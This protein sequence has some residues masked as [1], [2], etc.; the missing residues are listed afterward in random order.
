MVSQ[1][2]Y[3]ETYDVLDTRD[4]WQLIRMAFDR[5]EGWAEGLPGM[6]TD[7]HE[8]FIVHSPFIEEDDHI[9]PM[10][11]VTFSNP[12]PPAYSVRPIHY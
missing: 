12:K 1:I 6:D 10:G 5:Y 8:Q 2:L 9:L 7:L 11:S 3:G 4:E